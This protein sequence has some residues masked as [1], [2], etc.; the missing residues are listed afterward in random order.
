M[1][2]CLRDKTLLMLLEGNGTDK[3][4]SHLESCEACGERYR[5]MRRD[6]DLIKQA[7]EQDPPPSRLQPPQMPLIYRW[8]PVAAVLAVGITLGWGGS[9]V[10]RANSSSLS[11][12]LSE[13]EF[14]QFLDE[15][16]EAVFPGTNVR[17][18]SAAS[19]DSDFAFLQIALGESCSY[20]CEEVYFNSAIETRAF[21]PKDQPRGRERVQDGTE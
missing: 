14:A 1:T 2:R 16:S 3:E 8:V 19:P 18:A 7:L 5:Q 20:E 17:T 21:P 6:L 12:R 10:W 9:W 11:A 4:R 15:V 13:I